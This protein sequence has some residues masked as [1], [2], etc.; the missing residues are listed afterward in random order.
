MP[1]TTHPATS[2]PPAPRLAEPPLGSWHRGAAALAAGVVGLVALSRLSLPAYFA[3]AVEDGPVETLTFLGLLAVATV[4]A[5]RWVRFRKTRHWTWGALA[6]AAAAGFAFVAGEEVSW[7]QR[8]IGF[9]TPEVLLEANTQRE[10]N[11]H[12]LRLGGVS[13]N[14]L[15]FTRLL[16]VGLAA[17]LAV[18]PAVARRVA[19]VRRWARRAGVAW[20]PPGLAALAVALAALVTLIPH[21]TRWETLELLV[22]AIALLTLASRGVGAPA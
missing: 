7:G 15:V 3:W 11:L 16:A 12:N 1:P 17:Y 14:K 2:R 8:A 6:L 5:A 19:R 21:D 4:L 10:A 9:A 20:V 22:P 13:V 18:L